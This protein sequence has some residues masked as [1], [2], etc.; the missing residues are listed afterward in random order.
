MP[1]RKRAA[2]GVIDLTDESQN[3][4][5]KQVCGSNGQVQPPPSQSSYDED[6]E[7]YGDELIA[8]TQE[9]NEGTWRRLQFYGTLSTK[10]VGVQY[11]A[12]QAT[13]GE[14]FL[15]RREPNNMY[16]RNAIRALNVREEQIGH[17]PRAVAA[18]LAK[19]MDSNALRIEGG[20][21]GYIG[22][23]DCPIKLKLYGSSDEVVKRDLV[24]QMRAEKLPL[25]GI[26]EAE[27]ETRRNAKLEAGRLKELQKLQREAKK[28]GGAVVGGPQQYVGGGSVGIGPT[29]D[30]TDIINGSE[31]FTSRSVGQ[32]TEDYGKREAD[33]ETMPMAKQPEALSAELLPFQR[34]GLHWLLSKESPQVPAKGSN[35]ICQLWKRSSRDPNIITNI[36]TNFSLKGS[37]PA[38]ASGGILADDMGLG[39]TVQIISLIVADRAFRQ[40]DGLDTSATLIIAPLGVMSNWSSQIERHVK[41]KHRLRVMTYHGNRKLKLDA[42]EIKNY[43]VVITTYGTVATEYWSTKQPQVP[44]KQGLFS[45]EWRRVVVDEGHGLRN[46]TAKKTVAAMNLMA[47]SRWIL[48]GT[49][50]INTLKDFYSLTKFIRLSGGLDRFELFNAAIIRP[51]NAGDPLGIGLLQTLMQDICLRRRKDMKFVDLKLPKLTEYVHKITLLEHEQQKYDALEAEAK[52]TLSDYQARQASS[53]QSAMK[54]YR[55][56]LEIL[57]RMRQLCNHW[58]MC[59]EERFKDIM[60][61]L[62]KEKVLDLT[63]ENKAAL[64]SMLQ[65][66]I[67]SQEDC[68][69]CLD[70]LKEPVITCCAHIFCNACIETVIDTQRKCPMCRAELPAITSLVHPAKEEKPQQSNIDTENSSSKVEALLSILRASSK[71]MGTKT[72]VF[73]QW[74][75]FLDIVQAQLDEEGFNYT[76]IDGRMTATQRDSAMDELEKNEECTIMLASL[77]VCSVGLNLVAANQVVLADTWWA[78]AI[79]DQAIDRVHRLGQKKPTTVFRL[80]VEGSI[81]ENVLQI[82]GDKRKLMNLAFAE[83]AGKRDA[84]VKNARLADIERLLA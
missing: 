42:S 37:S 61:I 48:T 83:K 64:Q 1:S 36:A 35:D 33:L 56:L 77:G 30:L 5:N 47:Q 15:V 46:P 21:N 60:E 57:I 26:R 11:Y 73:S 19:Y 34:Q 63:P 20:I 39:K 69:I 59:G 67:E 17:I 54:A 80:V 76:R 72:V 10:I 55:H 44:M 66:N 74:T 7:A 81:E 70:N 29:P 16:D 28:N 3:R 50:I 32:M 71:K 51:V 18:K 24:N 31:R 82:Q 9:Y 75:T 65:L 23:F 49:P 78:P 22:Q 68:P 40:Q 13:A 45:V 38:M 52:G 6:L 2:L 41:T 84:G 58:K 27:A 25:D 43:D 62:E 8:G 12:G 4:S 79:E 14:L 53:G